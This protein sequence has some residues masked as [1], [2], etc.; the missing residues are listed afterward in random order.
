[1]ARREVVLRLGGYDESI[2]DL[3]EDQVLISK[4]AL[5]CRI[6]VDLNCGE[7]YR[8]HA[9]S[10][11]SQAVRDETYH[12][13]RPNPAR[14]AYL[15]WLRRYV[16]GQSPRTR[17]AVDPALRRAWRPYR[18]PDAYRHIARP[19]HEWESVRD[20]VLR[21]L[22]PEPLDAAACGSEGA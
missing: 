22:R 1:M 14:R 10:S 9:G 4:L 21:R 3:Y 5:N 16:A 7:K 20:R 17:D 11:S 12:P 18:H 15:V 6:R 19:A 13:W 2:Q 8:Q